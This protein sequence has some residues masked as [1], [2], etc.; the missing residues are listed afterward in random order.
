MSIHVKDEEGD[1]AGTADVG[2]TVD[3]ESFSRVLVWK[4]LEDSRANFSQAGTRPPIWE[5]GTSRCVF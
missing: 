5:S 1:Q 4:A 2:L 3:L